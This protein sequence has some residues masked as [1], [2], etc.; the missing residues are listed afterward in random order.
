[1]RL[2]D[3]WLYAHCHFDPLYL[4]PFDIRCA[5][6]QV[7]LVAKE[8]ADAPPTTDFGALLRDMPG[9]C[10]YSVQKAPATAAA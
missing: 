6:L 7:D 9:N 8:P 5:S 4:P 10:D 3:V 1:M 2:L